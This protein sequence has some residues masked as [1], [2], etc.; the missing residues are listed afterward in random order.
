[1]DH[2]GRSPIFTSPSPPS[3]P[4]PPPPPPQSKDSTTDVL[5]LS[6]LNLHKFI[7]TVLPAN[8]CT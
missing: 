3:L 8:D 4:T 7:Y 5:S 1:M 6:V 2:K